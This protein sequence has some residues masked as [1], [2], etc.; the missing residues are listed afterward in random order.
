[1]NSNT[2]KKVAPHLPILLLTL[3]SFAGNAAAES[4]KPVFLKAV[5]LSTVSSA[6]LSSFREEV[7]T[8]QKYQLVPNLSDNGRMDVVLTV[9]M[10]CTER[11]DVA[12]VATVYGKAKCSATKIATFRSTDPR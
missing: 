6:V 11:N 7:R 4:P 3:A 8:S 1:M 9:D 10:N 5:C 2:R 12:A